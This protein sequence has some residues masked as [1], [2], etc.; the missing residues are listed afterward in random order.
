MNNKMKVD[1]L[2][3]QLTKWI[4]SNARSPLEKSQ[5]LR[6]IVDEVSD[7]VIEDSDRISYI[8][9]P[10]A[11]VEVIDSQTGNLFRRYL[12]L[13]YNE[14]S[15]GLRLIGEDISGNDV[16][17]AYLS[18]TAIEHMHELGGNGPDQPRCED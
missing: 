16:Q 3:V 14:N 13:E 2:V 4:E 6:K 1:E 11:V 18:E 17:I 8:T 12:E 5:L 15:N 7:L 10:N 9:A